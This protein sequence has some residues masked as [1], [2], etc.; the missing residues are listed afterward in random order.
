MG[1]CY[2]Y[3]SNSLFHDL[4]DTEVVATQD[5]IYAILPSSG[6][7]MKLSA[8]GD[9]A[10]VDLQGA[11]PTRL[12]SSPD[13]T[14][15]LVFTDYLECKIDDDDIVYIADCTDDD[16]TTTSELAI[17]SGGNV[18]KVYDIPSHLNTVSFSDDGSIV[19][20][21]LEYDE[22]SPIQVDGFADLEKLLL[23]IFWMKVREVLLL[24]FLLL[25]SS[26]LPTTKLL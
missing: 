18:E 14:K 25:K 21:Y 24:D 5:A 19:V 13:G 17:L 10:Q 8:D 7:L 9:F 15:L 6:M 11:S 16:I 2:N 12:V 20:A 23:S 1:G 26:L 4:W 22:A 3:S